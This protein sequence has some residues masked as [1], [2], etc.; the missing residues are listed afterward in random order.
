MPLKDDPDWLTYGEAVRKH[1]ISTLDGGVSRREMASVLGVGRQAICSY[2]KGRT[3][4][5]P[6]IIEKM[7]SRWP[8]K[9]PFRGQEFDVGAYDMHAAEKGPTPTQPGLF[10]SLRA[11]RPEDLKVEIEG[12]TKRG[13]R[14]SVEIRIAS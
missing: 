5:K 8:A 4:P 6:H 10:E 14:L 11:I 9:L 3:V 7:L 12:V 1:I 13:I 2:V